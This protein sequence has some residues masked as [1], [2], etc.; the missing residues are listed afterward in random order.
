MCIQDIM[1]QYVNVSTQ[2]TGGWIKKQL[3]RQSLT[4]RL[5]DRQK[6]RIPWS[7]RLHRGLEILGVFQLFFLFLGVL[8]GLVLCG[9]VT[10]VLPISLCPLL[11]KLRD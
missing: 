1:I 3:K 6:D 2:Q 7:D 9:R 8:P 11:Y 4:D 10:G 5:T